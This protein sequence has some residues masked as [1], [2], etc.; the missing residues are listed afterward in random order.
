MLDDRTQA[1]MNAEEGLDETLGPEIPPVEGAVPAPEDS[2]LSS[3]LLLALVR[4]A[5]HHDAEEG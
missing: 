3:R 1:G 4:Q 2:G 5:R